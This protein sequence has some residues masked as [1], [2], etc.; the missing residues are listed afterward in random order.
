MGDQGRIREIIVFVPWILPRDLPT[1]TRKKRALSL[2]R[3][4]EHVS[5]KILRHRGSCTV[6]ED[7]S[8]GIVKRFLIFRQSQVCAGVLACVMSSERV[9][10]LCRRAITGLFQE[11]AKDKVWTLK[12][13]HASS[14]A[15]GQKVTGWGSWNPTPVQGIRRFTKT[16]EFATEVLAWKVFVSSAQNT[17]NRAN[18]PGGLPSSW[19][20]RGR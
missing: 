13:V 9:S 4:F 12:Q 16:R 10:L 18:F 20:S 14:C 17:E 8:K 19:A 6:S 7:S 11:P 5:R 15:V 2:G 3:R 1:F